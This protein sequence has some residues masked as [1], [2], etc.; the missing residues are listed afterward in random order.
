MVRP[1]ELRFSRLSIMDYGR[2]R[3]SSKISSFSSAVDVFVK[4]WIWPD[5]RYHNPGF[6]LSLTSKRVEKK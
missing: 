4:K 5:K 6:A 2:N 1:S 3:F